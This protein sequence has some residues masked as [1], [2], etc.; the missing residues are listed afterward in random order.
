MRITLLAN[1][2]LL[3]ALNRGEPVQGRD[4][5][6]GEAFTLAVARA[7]ALVIYFGEMNV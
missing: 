5:G 4:I 6:A 1:D 7:L 2:S 3:L